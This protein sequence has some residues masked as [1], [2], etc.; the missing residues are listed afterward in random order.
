MTWTPPRSWQPKEALTAQRFNQEIHDKIDALNHR[1]GDSITIPIL[2][3][4]EA[5]T[6]T[7]FVA[8]DDALFKR[9]VTTQGGDLILLATLP[10]VATSDDLVEVYFDIYVDGSYYLSSGSGTPR[11]TGLTANAM[12]LST[13]SAMV[14]IHTLIP[15]SSV[16]IHTVS[17]HWRV[18]SDTGT[19]YT[20]QTQGHMLVMEV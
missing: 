18:A 10:R 17:L 19:I 2:G 7:T 5:T 12:S 15:I 14:Q 8:I 11:D 16:G 13:L 1:P 3:G 9:T 20:T 4:D 6:S